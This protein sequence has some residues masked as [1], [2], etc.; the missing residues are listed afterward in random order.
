MRGRLSGQPR[1]SYKVW[2]SL[3][4]LAHGEGN[5]N[6]RLECFSGLQVQ[7]NEITMGSRLETLSGNTAVL[8]GPDPGRPSNSHYVEHASGRTPLC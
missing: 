5:K 2:G 6:P 7:S 3:Y 1:T 8:P 4:T